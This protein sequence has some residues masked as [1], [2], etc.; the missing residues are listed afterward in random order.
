MIRSERFIFLDYTQQCIGRIYTNFYRTDNWLR[1]T[2]YGSELQNHNDLNRASG[3]S[4]LYSTRE[5]LVYEHHLYL[6]HLVE[7]ETVVLESPCF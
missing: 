1:R 4:G 3:K 2:E 5:M 7:R 6:Y